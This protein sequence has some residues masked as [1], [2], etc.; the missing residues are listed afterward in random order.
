MRLPDELAA[1]ERLAVS[2]RQGWKRVEKLQFGPHT[3]HDVA[4]SLTKGSD[5]RFGADKLLFYEGSKRRQTFGFLVSTGGELAWRGAAATNLH[6]RALERGIEVEL[7]NQSGFAATLTSATDPGEVWTPEMTE[8]GE[9]PLKGTLRRGDAFIDI[10]GTNRLAASRLPLGETTGYIVR[11]GHDVVA[12]AEVI[13][14]GAVWI[15][16]NTEAAH[17][18][19]ILAALSAL[20][21]LEEL[22]PTLPE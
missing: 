10:E 20:L 3:A 18:G 15:S 2:G 1:V 21:L 11:D 9:R 4:R 7:R 5:L 19:P 17:R 14:K 22:R 12:A 16:P 13:N 8:S 6:R